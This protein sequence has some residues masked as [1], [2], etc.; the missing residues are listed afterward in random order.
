VESSAR[1]KVL[2]VAHRTAV[3]PGLIEEVRREAAEGDAAFTLVVPR[4]PADAAPDSH[5]AEETL[6]LALPALEEAAGGHVDGMVGDSDPFVAVR[7]V[8]RQEDFDAVIVST[9]PQRI[10]RWLRRD[11]PTRVEQLGLPVRTVTAP[12][13]ERMVLPYAP[14]HGYGT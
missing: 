3:A 10:S 9:L 5:E 14:P 8:I 7:E 1:R 11:L 2:I 6:E 13:P 12:G 4:P